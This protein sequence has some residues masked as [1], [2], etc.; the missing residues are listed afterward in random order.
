MFDS[1]LRNPKGF[2]E[3]VITNN[4]EMKRREFFAKTS[5]ATLASLI[6]F[7]ASNLNMAYANI[8]SSKIHVK[9][10]RFLFFDLWKLDYWDNCQLMQGRTEF[11]PEATYEDNSVPNQGAGKPNVYYDNTSKVWRMLYN[12]GWGPVGLMTAIS[13]D[14]IKWKPDPHPE[15][16]IPKNA[17]NRAA[18]HHIFQLNNSAAGG[19]YQDPIAL[20]GFPF[21]LFV[22]L[23]GEQVF[24]RALAEPG[25]L[26]HSSAL[27]GGNYRTFHEGKVLVSQ[28]GFHWQLH[29]DYYWS[30]SDWHPEPPYFAFYN[31]ESKQHSMIVR[32]GWGDRRM[33]IQTTGDFKN[34]TNPELLLQM[35]PI[36]TA[37]LG[38]YAMP[39][40]KYAQMYIGL[41][42]IFHNSSSQPVNSFNQF[43]GTMDTQL[44]YSYDGKRFIRGLREPI[45]P[46]NPYP[47]HGC[48]QLRP[49]SIIEQEKEI[50]IYSGASRAPHGLENALQRQAC[51]TINAIV[52]HRLR[53]DGWMYI[54]S[55]GHWARIQTKP[56]GIWSSDILL[57]ASAPFGLVRYQVTDEKSQPIENFTFE[58]CIPLQAN[59]AL[60]WSMQWQKGKL[61][62]LIGKII[63]IEIEFYNAKIYSLTTAYHMLDAQDKWLIEDGKTIDPSRFDY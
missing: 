44:A 63:R 50:R 1:E 30:R 58:E 51:T 36:D 19:F 27:K 55:V 7:P 17:G 10:K 60:N 62:D 32:P 18:N 5:L 59:D 53:K 6:N 13:N 38:F 35:D 4:N 37:P 14:G 8:V 28:D 56:M 12:L 52:M 42:W 23:D 41:L 11:V 31:E 15:I 39:V 46:L 24:R 25:H 29:P 43:Y 20:D 21:K 34:W 16:K 57:N 54:R 47:I 40:I 61:T 9:T 3:I 45:L 33:A 49:Y 2:W 26:L 22:Q 48:T